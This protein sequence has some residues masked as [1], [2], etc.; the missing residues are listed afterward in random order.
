MTSCDDLLHVERTN[1]ESLLKGV[2]KS[3]NDCP[4]DE[5]VPEQLYSTD[6]V[7]ELMG[8]SAR[9]VLMLPIRQI[10]IGARTMRFR[11]GDVYDF[12]G[13]DNPNE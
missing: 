9:T 10:R 13:L 11:L 2:S 8:V 7:A 3:M 5:L 12:L 1:H 4:D 6:D